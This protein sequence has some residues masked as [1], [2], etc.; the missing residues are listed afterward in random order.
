MS[1]TPLD[2]ILRLSEV[3][4][5]LYHVRRRRGQAL[6]ISA[7]QEVRVAEA[8]RGLERLKEQQKT[9]ARETTRV[10]G[11]AKA[12]TAEIDKAQAALNQAKTNDEYQALLRAIEHKKAELGELETKILEGYEVHEGR[13]AEQKA[14]EVKLKQFDGELAE[15]RKR[16]AQELSTIDAELGRLEAQRTEIAAAVPAEHLALYQRVLEQNKDSAT[17]AVVKDICQGC[18]M[19]VRPE[20]V[21][22]VRGKHLASCFTCSRILY[23]PD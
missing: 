7:P 20:Q 3:D 22:Q 21:S 13:V 23:L 14:I 9:L 2:A 6:Q 15:A 5:A 18:F 8:R 12:K 17:A 1:D 11:D 4:R 16:V 19:K 10:E